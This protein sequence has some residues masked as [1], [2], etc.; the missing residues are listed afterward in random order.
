[1]LMANDNHLPLIAAANRASSSLLR[2]ERAYTRPGLHIQLKA[3][4][5]SLL[6][7]FSRVVNLKR[8][9]PRI[10]F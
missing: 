6:Q 2:Q 8:D 5:L 4:F 10:H 9:F 3:V 7:T 1:M